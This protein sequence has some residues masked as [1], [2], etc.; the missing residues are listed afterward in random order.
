MYIETLGDGPDLVLLHG[1]AMHSGVFAPLTR[2][3]A[4]R[5]RLHLVDLP[6]HGNS[7][8][9]EGPLDLGDAARRIAAHVPPALWI[10][11][12][13]GGQV[14]LQAALAAESTVQALCLIASSPRFV[15]GPDWPHGVAATVFDDFADGLRKDYRRTVERFLALEAMGSDHAQSELRELKAQVFARGE[16]SLHVLCAGLKILETV[17]MRAQIPQLRVPSLWIA[18]RRDRLIPHGAMQWAAEHAPA[19][20]YLD[21][22]AGHAPFVGHAAAIAE[23]IAA[24][25]AEVVRP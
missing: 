7:P 23:A 22:S 18:G 3:L 5:F 14:C 10:G 25:H 16:P 13:L 21:F 11:W 12:S 6:G 20:R 19:G 2:A 9:R 8:E 4:P 1:W 15:E 24:F 17:D